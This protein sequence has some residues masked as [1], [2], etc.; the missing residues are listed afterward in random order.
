MDYLSILEKVLPKSVSHSSTIL[1]HVSQALPHVAWFA[2]M[3]NIAA[4]G[5]SLLVVFVSQ[6]FRQ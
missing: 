3:R 4:I 2:W 6:E 1:V 5:Y